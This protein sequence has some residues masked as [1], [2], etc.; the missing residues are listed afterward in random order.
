MPRIVFISDRGGAPEVFI[1][2]ETGAGIQ[3]LSRTTAADRD[4]TF[5]PR[6]GRLAY[7]AAGAADSAA[8]TLT[9]MNADGKKVSRVAKLASV[10]S[11]AWSPDDQWIAFF[12]DRDGN[13]EVY[14]ARANGKEAE[15]LT[16]NPAAD[17]DP[18]F[19]PDGLQIAFVSD[20]AGRPAIYLMNAETGGDLLR[21]TPP[22]LPAASA[23]SFSPDGRYIVFSAG[24]DIYVIQWNGKDLRRLTHGASTNKTPV[25]SPDGSRI[26]FSS[27]R[28]GNFAIYTMDLNG[29][30]LK[31][32]TFGPSNDTHPTWW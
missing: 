25:F 2:W 27:N 3:R 8:G 30:S 16:N 21:V 29:G 26:A 17:T 19:S 24:G 5:S 10:R 14:V 1:V 7:V 31:Q 18:A 23:P 32:I 15:R 28:G 11:P 22:D 4:V 13:P 6:R 9:L 12:S 20:R